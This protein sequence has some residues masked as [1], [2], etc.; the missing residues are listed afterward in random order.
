MND[1][2]KT[3]QALIDELQALRQ[4]VA[5]AEP[6]SVQI[7]N[8]LGGAIHV[9]DSDLRIL[10]RNS[11]FAEWM[12]YLGLEGE[13]VGKLVTD[14]F[15][16]LPTDVVDE[17]RRVFQSGGAITTEECNDV[18]GKPVWTETRKIPIAEDGKVVRVL[19]VIRDITELKRTHGEL[20]DQ[21]RQRT[22]QLLRINA[23]LEAESAKREEATGSCAEVRIFSDR[24]N[25]WPMW[26]VGNGAWNQTG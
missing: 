8:S 2:N 26:G 4:R 13:I 1:R 12:A 16:F 21:V 10:V 14:A 19:T 5:P 17:Y 20:E 7:L 6:I 3:K 15:T 24:Q 23:D 11:A 18:R 22:D 25:E 9:V